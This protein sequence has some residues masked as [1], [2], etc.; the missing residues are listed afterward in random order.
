MRHL[1]VWTPEGKP[2]GMTLVRFSVSICLV[3]AVLRVF[4]GPLNLKVR[5]WPTVGWVSSWS[6]PEHFGE[7]R[8]RVQSRLEELP[9]QQLVLVRYAS[10]HNSMDEWVYNQADIDGSKVVWAREMDAANNLE[11]LHYYHDRKAWLVEPDA[12][13]AVVVPYPAAE[14]STAAGK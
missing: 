7:P 10:D 9:G 3:M 6:G 13:P 1:R 2:V 8:A 14:P 5:E 12:Q 4:S 11:L